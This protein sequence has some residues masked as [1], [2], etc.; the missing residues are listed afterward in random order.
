MKPKHLKEQRLKEVRSIQQRQW[1]ISVEIRNLGYIELPK[2]IRHGWFKEIVITYNI[3]R[4]RNKKYILELFEVIEKRFWGSTKSKA[5]KQWFHQVSKYLIYK[6]FPTISKKQFNR[7]TPKAQA[8]C[9]VYQYRDCQKKMRKRFY[10]RIPKGAY[11]IKYTRAYITH[12]KRIDPLLESEYTLLDQQLLKKEY[13]KTTQKL[14][15]WSGKDYW[16]VSKVKKDKL[17]AK[18]QLKALKNYLLDDVVKQII[19][20]EKN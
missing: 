16:S 10:I 9:T 15:R 18:K 1:E 3:D 14:Y 5:D 8:M 13:Y 11:K 2:P 12:S 4:Y 19:S 6:D 17:K 7:L 20:W